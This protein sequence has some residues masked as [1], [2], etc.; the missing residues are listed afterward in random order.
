M[1]QMPQRPTQ[2]T[3]PGTP[4]PGLK[5]ASTNLGKT[6]V[7]QMQPKTII[8]NATGF[9]AAYDGALNPYSGCSL[10]CNYCYASN[11]T[12]DQNDKDN[13]GRWVR[14]KTNAQQLMSELRPGA[15]NHKVYYISTVTDPYQP[16]ERKAEVTRTI[17]ADIARNH[18]KAKL[19]IQTRCPLV[20]RDIDLFNQI[21]QSGGKVQVNMTVTTDNDETRKTYEP[22]C[23][24]INARLKA[25]TA[26][27]L[28]GI[29]SCITLTPLLPVTDLEQFI[30]TLRDTRVK[31]FIVQDFHLPDTGGNNFVARTDARAIESTARH[32]QSQPREAAK[33]YRAEYA[34]TLRLLKQAIPGIGVGKRGFAPPF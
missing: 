32:Y 13:W 25:I 26:V 24:S 15:L 1:N 12:R 19:V 9:I 17:L 22:G 3:L 5:T 29:Q 16:V 23:P 34:E 27:A 28:A 33:Q 30:Q 14:V 18:P 6:V 20:T 2:A 7:T 21:C 8:G 4:P 10:G 31:R 11:F